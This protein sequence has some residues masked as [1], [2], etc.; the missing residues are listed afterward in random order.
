MVKK[1]FQLAVLTSAAL[2][3]CV[4]PVSAQTAK[5]LPELAS[6]ERELKG[7]ETH[8]YRVSLPA[9]KFLHAIVEQKEI[10]LIAAAFAPDG[11]QLTNC[12]S[13]N[14]RWGSESI[15]LVASEAGEYRVDVISPNSKA[16]PGRYRI[17]IVALR[18]ATA[19]DKGHAAAL[20]AFDEGRKLRA[21]PNADAKRAAIAKFEQALPLFRAAGDTYRE[22]MTWQSIGVAYYPLNEF[23]KALECF[24]QAVTLARSIG[25]RRFESGTETWIAGMLD[26]LGDV[27]KALDH[28]Q[29]ALKLARENG[30]RLAEASALSS[31][32]KIYNDMSE[33]DKA[34]AF[35]AQALPIFKDQKSPRDEAI[36]LNNIGIAYSLSGEQEKAL[37]YLQQSL[38]LLRRGTDKNVLAYTLLNIGRAYRRLGEYKKALTHL[39]EAQS[40]QQETG[41]RAQRGETLDE[42]GAVYSDQGQHDKAVDYHRQAV[43]TLRAA[44]SIR[45]EAMA[46]NQLGE[47]YNLLNQ[48]EKA[49]D[50]FNSALA[51]FRNINDP[52]NAASSL[53]GIARSESKRGRIEDARS[54]MIESLALRETIRAR[55]GSLQL[56]ASY[57]ATVEDAY[58][59]YID[60]LM[61]Q[62]AGNPSGGFDAEALH[63]S[64]RDRARS[65]LEHLSETRIDIRR[66][67]DAGLLEKERDLTRVLNAKA[68]REM[69]VKARKGSNEELAALQREISALEDE[70]QQVQAAIRRSSPEYAALTQ[71]Q[72]LRLKEIQ[73][74]LDA[75]TL[76]LEY[77]LGSE[78]SYLWVVGQNSLK[79][80]VLPERE[81]IEKVARQIYE[82]LTARSVTKSLET[83]AQRSSRVAQ[84]DRDFQTATAELSRMILAPAA[85]E[86][87]NRR[88]VVV[89]DDALQYVPFSALSISSAAYQPLI[90]RH[91]IIS[92]QSA[93]AFAVQRQNLANREPAPKTLAVIAD[94]VFSASDPRLKNEAGASSA[95][96][97]TRTL[98][99]LPANAINGSLSIPRLPFTRWEADQ[100]LA[101]ARAGSNLK[102]LDF[103]ANRAMATSGELSKY[104]YVH[105]ATHGYLDTTRA[106][107]SAIV[108]SLFD[109]QGKPQD[110]FLRTHDI[111]NLKLPAELVVLSACE[112]GLGKDVRGEGLEGLTRGFMYAG[113][114]RVIVSLWNVNDKATASLMQRLYAGMLRSNKTPA[115]ALRAAQ[116]EMLRAGQWQSPYYWAAFV[117]QGEWR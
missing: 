52:R 83:R 109:A 39:D 59:F 17:Q 43:E 68:Q 95:P 102:A 89:A 55:S 111:Y 11:K 3:M 42:I 67:V 96:D 32:G 4:L 22:G 84:A 5:D 62:H 100:I 79:A 29:R 80:Y 31:I 66:G 6:V 70:Y 12:D 74:Q 77:S 101:V 76:L 35:Y 73:Q 9:G 82:S 115:A 14:D 51:I 21:Q 8:S 1:L 49:L 113:A 53:E 69:Q 50:Q 86:F 2:V 112:T 81:Q 114:R 36:A 60:V 28:N 26:I 25:D 97:S 58:E 27:V 16:R 103:R 107:L 15:L 46:L 98:E 91:E 93:S 24:N 87:G 88:L 72:P 94:P 54:R 104:R 78:R 106:G 75:D 44:G 65:L 18:E 110:G 105:F 33:W 92:L 37:E 10:D 116:I 90:L 20:L 41:S 85:G 45:R 13:P 23:R 48:P 71:P 40:V 99:H 34:L 38:D 19:T 64:E 57:R 47:V 30:W 108:L 117:T 61:Q 56:R 63:A 7:G